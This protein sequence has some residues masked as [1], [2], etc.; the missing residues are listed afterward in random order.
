MASPT[1]EQAALY[2]AMIDA[3]VNVS[4]I[5][6]ELLATF[7]QEDK[8]EACEEAVSMLGDFR[9]HEVWDEFGPD[10]LAAQVWSLLEYDVEDGDATTP[11]A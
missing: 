3:Q 5:A 9:P 1:P 11:D 4:R 8:D 2:Q 10:Y 6:E 7:T